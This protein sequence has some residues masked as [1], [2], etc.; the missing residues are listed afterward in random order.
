[1]ASVD[2]A[3]TL[4]G[5]SD[6]TFDHICDPCNF[7]GTQKQGTSYC[8]HCKEKLCQTCTDAHKGQQISRNHNLIPISK[9]SVTAAPPTTCNVLCDC[10][11]NSA[12]VK[13]CQDH[14]DVICQPCCFTKHRACKTVSIG[15]KSASYQRGKFT[16]V[17]LKADMLS[18]D[19]D[20]ALDERKSDLQLYTTMTETAK[21]DMG[22]Y[23]EKIN[24]QFDAMEKEILAELDRREARNRQHVDGHISSCTTTKQLLQSDLMILNDAKKAADKADMFAADVKVS[25]RLADYERLLRDIRRESTSISLTFK[26]NDQILDMLVNTKSIGTL[27]EQTIEKTVFTYLKFEN[28]KKKKVKISKDKKPPSIT[29]CAFM[30]DGKVLLTDVENDNLKLLDKSFTLQDSLDLPSYP[31]DVSVVNDTTAIITLPYPEQ[32]QYIDVAPRLAAGRVIQLDKRCYGVQVVGSDI[33]VTCHHYPAGE[34]EV[35]ILDKNGNM[36]KR[37]GVNQDNTFM[38]TNPHHLTVSARSN[39]IYVSDRD[40]HTLTCLKTD[41]TVIFQYKDPE[42]DGPLGVCVDDEDNVMVCGGESNNLHVVTS[43]G[44]KHSVIL[45]SKDGIKLPGC[46]AYRQTDKTLIVGCWENNNIYVF[47]VLPNKI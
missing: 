7:R 4:L 40:Q 30:P 39:K 43:D 31:W 20:R 9:L 28:L 8:K 27:I 12:V 18:D 5:A 34:G 17:A 26:N 1:M 46:V 14:D 38:F 33:Y 15:E 37:L 2:R 41:G 3:S 29:G 10:S 24:S 44:K 13:Y 32:L 22:K 11:Q 25:K 6:E 21:T 47:H 16:A 42:L 19:T 45:T 23:R 36:R 35:R